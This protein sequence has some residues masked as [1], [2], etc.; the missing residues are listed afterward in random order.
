MTKFNYE[1]VNHVYTF[2]ATLAVIQLSGKFAKSAYLID[3]C[4][5]MSGM[6]ELEDIRCNKN[7][8]SVNF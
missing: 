1:P 7:C 3:C 8:S 4:R 6:D 2:L 5:Y